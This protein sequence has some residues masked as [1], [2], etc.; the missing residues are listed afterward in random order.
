MTIRLPAWLE[1]VIAAV[2]GYLRGRIDQAD[3]DDAAARAKS[4][5]AQKAVEDAAR[6]VGALT[7]DEVN[8]ELEQWRR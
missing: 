8:S 2:A 4:Q 6:E 3:A 1:A 5:S 7:D